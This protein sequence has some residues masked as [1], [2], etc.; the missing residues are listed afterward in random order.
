VPAKADRHLVGTRPC[1]R[2]RTRVSLPGGARFTPATCGAVCRRWPS[3]FQRCGAA[4][5]SGPLSHTR[6]RWLRRPRGTAGGAGSGPARPR[7]RAAAF[8]ND[9]LYVARMTN[10]QALDGRR[11]PLAGTG[12]TVSGSTASQTAHA[13]GLSGA[14]AP[15]RPIARRSRWGRF[16]ASPGD[17]GDSSERR[18]GSTA[19]RGGVSSPGSARAS[20]P[21]SRGS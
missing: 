21:A 9:E 7:S 6:A 10:D 13:T 11:R 12:A 5:G 16:D 17:R 15:G 4:R 3:A 20:H 18:L 2:V 8:E 19:T 1:N 14:G